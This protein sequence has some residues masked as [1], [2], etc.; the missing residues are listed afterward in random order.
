[1]TVEELY[2]IL[3]ISGIILTILL[4]IIGFGIRIAIVELTTGMKTISLQLSDIKIAFS[5]TSEQVNTAQTEI[6][7]LRERA[8]ATDEFKTEL[9]KN[10][11]LNK[12]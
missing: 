2:F 3:K 9:F 11:Q 7:N 12:R 6:N 4:G 1:M 8:D 10:Y 5:K